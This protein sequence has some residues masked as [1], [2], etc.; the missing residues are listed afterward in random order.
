VKHNLGK[1]IFI[2]L[3]AFVNAEVLQAK[4]FEYSIHL[5]KQNP[6]LKEAVILRFDVNQTNHNKVLFFDFDVLQSPSYSAQRI[7]IEEHDSY[8]NIQIRYTY[9]IYPLIEEALSIAFTLTQ[10]ATTDES[11]AYSF[12][13]DRDNVKT[14][15]TNDTKIAVPPL[16]LK[17]KALPKGTDIVGDFTLDY[18]IKTHTAKIHEPM[19][20]KVTLKGL[21][22]P[23]ILEHLLPSKTA[24]TQFTE[25]PLH[26]NTTSI[27]GIQSVVEYPMALSHDQNFSL[28]RIEIHAFNPTL[29]KSYT[30]IVPRQ[31]FTINQIPQN[32]LLDKI[33]S[34][35]PF[36]IDWA[37][38]SNI[39]GYLIVF[40]MG[41]TL[42]QLKKVPKYN[43]IAKISKHT[44]LANKIAQ[45]QTHKALLQLLMAQNHK[46]FNATI[47]KLDAVCYDNKSI[48]LKQLKK[49][50][51]ENINA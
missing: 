12:S 32:V 42:A 49:E 13:G 24:F 16:R 4:D 9:L 2:L 29:E 23:P 6:Y 37:W 19:P 34:P 47:S 51:Q 17:I 44:E 20:L 38:L 43:H 25:T 15:K 39:L 18:H 33:D 26:S 21:G 3:F 40:T 30:L 7:D 27:K 46:A 36:K 41:Y 14:L 5:D 1:V 35:P 31:D 11:V 8:H 48:S 45:T 28:E 22:Y 50:A 10:K